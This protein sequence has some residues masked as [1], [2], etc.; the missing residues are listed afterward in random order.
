MKQQIHQPDWSFIQNGA[1]NLFLRPEVMEDA[2]EKVKRQGYRVYRFDCAT[3]AQFVREMTRNLAWEKHF[4]YRPDAI[5]LDSF[6]DAL[7][8]EPFE[9]TD[10][11][12]LV[13]SRFTGFWKRDKARG[14]DVLDILECASRDY[15]LWGKRILVFVQVSNP[16]FQ[17]QG[18]GGRDARWNPREWLLK[19]RGL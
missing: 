2:V 3:D 12:V 9:S 19:D 10:R 14:W 6:N 13:L 16:K 4:G 1:T 11:A 7:R 18:L 5:G 17:A 8:Y 15:L